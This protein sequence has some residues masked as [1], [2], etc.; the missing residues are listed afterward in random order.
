ML[1]FVAGEPKPQGSKTAYKRGSKIVLVE[2]NKSLP[3]WRRRLVEGFAPFKGLT[4]QPGY[5]NGV[6]V[7]VEFYLSRPASVKRDYPTVKPDLDK[8]QR[9][10]GDAL[11]IAGVIKDDSSIV[12]WIASKYYAD[13]MEP[14]VTVEVIGHADITKT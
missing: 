14:G 1:I 4:T 5:E 8:L 11:T 12:Q 9:A 6:T 7:T 3:E 13:N 2:A 10:V